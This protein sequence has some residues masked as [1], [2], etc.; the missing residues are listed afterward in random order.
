MTRRQGVRGSSMV[1]FT[2]V[3]FPLIFILI[4]IFEMA[5]G[6]WNYH[7]LE[8]AVEVGTQYMAVHGSDLQ[9][10]STCA[11]NE[12]S[13][14]ASLNGIATA[15]ANAAVGLPSSTW[16]VTLTAGSASQS[17]SPLSNC[18]GVTTTWPPSGNNT[19]GTAIEISAT[20]NFQ[21]ALSYFWP[22]ATSF[23]FGTMTFAAESQQ[24][25][26]Y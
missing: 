21:N 6:M 3:G 17:C 19:P 1:E 26:L 25:I 7:T 20:Y 23:V 4:A 9:A 15:L 12:N 13:C 22:G 24:T 11:S 14:G 5:R 10:Q 8:E 2:L 16:N 18:V